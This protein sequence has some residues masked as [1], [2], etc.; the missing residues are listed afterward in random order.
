MPKLPRASGDKHIAAFKR[1]G[2]KVNHIEGSHSLHPDKRRKRYSSVYTGA[3]R[4]NARYRSSEEDY[5]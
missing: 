4:Q 1:A 5:C 3:Q 2:W